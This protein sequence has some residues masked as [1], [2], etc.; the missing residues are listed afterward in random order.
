MAIAIKLN[1][2]LVHVRSDTRLSQVLD[3]FDVPHALFFRSSQFQWKSYDFFLR[4][5]N[6]ELVY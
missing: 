3:C 6:E 1:R 2:T 4:P 5:T